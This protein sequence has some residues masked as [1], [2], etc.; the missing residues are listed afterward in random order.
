MLIVIYVGLLTNLFTH[1][2]FCHQTIIVKV[3]VSSIK[4]AT[5]S[6]F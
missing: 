4:V 2:H 6:V 1:T 5:R 3:A